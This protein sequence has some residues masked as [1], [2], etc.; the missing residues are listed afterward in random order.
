MVFNIHPASGAE[1]WWNANWRYRKTIT[2]NHLKV[3]GSLT[4]F[5][6]LVSLTDSDL[7]SKA[8][9]DGRD[10]VFTDASLVKLDH[11][12]ESF[13]HSTGTLNAWVKA[14]V[15]SSVDT[16][17]QM[18]YGNPAASNQQNPTGV[19]DSNFVMVQHLSEAGT[20]SSSPAPWHQYEG[21]PILSHST[22][23]FGSAFYDSDTGIYHFYCSWGSIL[24][25]T[26]PNG[27]TGWTADPLNPMLAGNNEGVPTVWKEGTTVYALQVWWAGQDWA[28]DFDGCQSLD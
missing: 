14:N 7:A 23:G 12:I 13:N 15:S 28:C 16:V 2:I 1:E 9:S 17:L 8:Q 5:P 11:E 19:W 10:I 20:A 18:Y 25:Y 26:S 4:G 21:N 6:V 22:D 27:K 3:S 24:H